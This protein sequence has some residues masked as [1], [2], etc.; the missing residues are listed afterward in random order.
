[1]IPGGEGGADT[2]VQQVPGEQPVQLSLSRT[3]LFQ[4]QGQGLLLHGPLRLFP[5]GFAEGVIHVDIVEAGGQRSLPLLFPHH[6]GEG[7]QGGGTG[8]RHGLPA[9]L[10]CGHAEH[11]AVTR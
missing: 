9:Q 11:L 2:L 3:S 1:M 5:G 6:I 10:F 7:E 8:Q 4:G